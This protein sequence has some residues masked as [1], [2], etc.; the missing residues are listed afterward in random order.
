[1]RG[2]GAIPGAGAGGNPSAGAAGGGEGGRTGVPLPG[3]IRPYAFPAVEQ[4]RLANGMEVRVVHKLPFPV[5]TAMVVIRAGETAAP[6]DRGGLAVLS[7]DA[8]EGGTVNRTSRE[9]AMELE[10]VGA[11][12]GAA[13]GWDS[14]TVALS[15]M[16]DRLRGA[17][18]LLAEMVRSPAFPASDFERYR[19]QRLAA[20]AHRRMDPASLAADAYARF[21]FGD[22]DTY[23]RPLSGTGSSLAGLGPGDA[24][25]FVKA[26]Y[27][28]SQSALIVAGDIEPAEALALGERSFGGWSREVERAPE[29]RVSARRPGRRVHLVHRPGSVQS[30]IRVGH[31]GVSRFVADYFPV[32]VVNL[33]LGGFFSSRLN[34]NLR[35]RNGFTYGVRSSFA[36]RRG[37]GPFVVSTSVENAVTGAATEEIHREIE[38]IAEKGPTE[39]EV[40]AA[41]SY[42]AGVFPLR[43]E[44]TGQIASR[45]AEMVIYD[46]PADYYRT[47]RDRVRR[48]T[49]EQAAES[50]HRHIRPDALCTVVVGDADE[51][52]GPLEALGIGPVVVHRDDEVSGGA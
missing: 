7:G 33:V 18:P 14:T 44:T 5:V 17:L 52:A 39:E 4:G 1:M 40:E 38:T 31:V 20:A 46:L 25:A 16:A 35:E 22:G 24:R 51:V 10:S 42:L 23:A 29:P 30:E 34:L 36:T 19:A 48:V 41:T 11:S 8:L 49:R 37:P 12:F 50:A 27:G 3:A 28:P 6:E 15:C 13:A 2:S 9:L 21:V 43:L 32:T 47:Y 26:R 45:V